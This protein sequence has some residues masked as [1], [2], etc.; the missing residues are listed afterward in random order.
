MS[1]SSAL[2]GPELFTFSADTV[3][4]PLRV[5]ER[6]R[7]GSTHN[8]VLHVTPRQTGTATHAHTNTYVIMP[9]VISA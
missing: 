5:K 3:G 9:S 6:P 1:R 8:Q 4:D 2:N 7:V